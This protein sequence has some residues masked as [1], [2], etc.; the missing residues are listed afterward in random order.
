MREIRPYG[1]EGGGIETNQSFLP[2]LI[3]EVEH[4]RNQDLT[5]ATLSRIRLNQSRTL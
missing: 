1:S 4:Q 5:V 3:H 2:Y